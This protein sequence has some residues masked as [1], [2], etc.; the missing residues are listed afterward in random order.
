MLRRI[1]VA[2]GVSIMLVGGVLPANADDEDD[3]GNKKQHQAILNAVKSGTDSDTT[4]HEAQNATHAA[5]SQKV[6]EVRTAIGNISTGGS[7]AGDQSGLPPTWDKVLSANN[8][9]D[10]CNSSRFKCVMPTAANPNGEAARDNETGLVWEKSPLPTF[11]TWAAVGFQC[12]ERMT[13]GRKGWRLPSFAELASLVDPSVSINGTDPTLPPGH[14]F[15]NV[16][17]SLY[18][19]ATTHADVPSEAWSV[20]L[21]NG[22]TFPFNKAFN[23]FVWCVRGGMNA[24]QY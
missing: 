24:D 23:G 20:N 7:T 1:V 21:I 13:G 22:V 4:A 11:L 3:Q 2:I 10:P 18:W 5:L 19:S 9:G 12:A 16:Q 15:S 6:D 14:P 8:P 17:A